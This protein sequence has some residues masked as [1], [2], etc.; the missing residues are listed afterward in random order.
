MPDQPRS[1]PQPPADW[2]EWLTQSERQWNT[3]LNSMMG[4]DQFGQTL[5]QFMNVQMA[6][7][8]SM[9]EAFERYQRALMP[10]ST[11]N[12]ALG[13][14][15]AAIEQRLDRLEAG[16]GPSPARKTARKR[17]PRTKRPP[18]ETKR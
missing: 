3:F 2:R 13:E 4:S 7:Q 14:R 6:A 17:P 1:A 15:L 9:G 11:D 12:V 8:K 16:A 10:G 18:S 5:A